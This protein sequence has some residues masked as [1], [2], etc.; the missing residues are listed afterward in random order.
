MEETD[1]SLPL[2]TPV[3]GNAPESASE[4]AVSANPEFILPMVL[5][6]HSA[7]IGVSGTRMDDRGIVVAG[8]ITGA[9]RGSIEV[10]IQRTNCAERLLVIRDYGRERR[11]PPTYPP[12]RRT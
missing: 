3:P 5:V 4:S 11:R 7:I 6:C 2:S 12:P 9:D 1:A 10:L 8:R